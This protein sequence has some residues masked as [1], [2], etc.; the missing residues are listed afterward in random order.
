[1]SQLTQ[2]LLILVQISVYSRSSSSTL[3][4]AQTVFQFHVRLDLFILSVKYLQQMLYVQKLKMWQNKS[5]VSLGEVY[6][7]NH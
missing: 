7:P 4:L 3:A 2:K 6:G 5:L 1:M